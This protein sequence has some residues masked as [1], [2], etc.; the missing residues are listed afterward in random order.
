[1]RYLGHVGTGFTD[2]HRD[3]IHA[4]LL[5]L[6]EPTSPFAGPLPRE[7][8]RHARWVLPVLV[9]EVEYRHLTPEGHLRHPSW[10]G[11]RPDREA[12]TIHAPSKPAASQS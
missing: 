9:G 2:R 10:R 12:A 8:T 1:M 3:L 11:L 5:D 7:H 4:A 6:D